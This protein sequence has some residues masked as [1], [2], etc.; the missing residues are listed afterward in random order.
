MN[1]L[2]IQKNRN[3]FVLAIVSAMM[4]VLFSFMGAPFLRALFI[5]TK[6]RVFW[7][8]A[9][10]LVG[11]LLVAGATNY[12]IAE[13]AVYAGA[14]W[15]TLGAYS[16]LEKRGIS[17][18]KSGLISL[19][20]GLLLASAGYFFILKNLTTTDLLGEMVEPLRAAINKVTSEPKERNFYVRVLPGIFV[21]G[22]I[23]SLA[24]SFAFEAKVA[25]M[26]KIQHE[27]VVSGLRWLEFSLPGPAIWTALFALL[28]CEFDTK[29]SLLFS[30]SLNIL[31]ALTVAFFFQGVV[32]V[33]SM[34]RGYRFGM[35]GRIVTYVL[36]ILQ[37]A[38]FV[39]FVG[40][41]DYWANFRRLV[42]KNKNYI[43]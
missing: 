10:L 12:K 5:S 40:F 15:M 38:P 22:L 35:F 41:V 9:I 17:W 1:L 33:E 42:R 8:T 30:I 31:I 39:V 4:S 29:E 14:T 2:K 24:F 20:A 16:E 6:S 34:L 7:I 26:F 43:N 25:K 32:V 19:S 28:I 18:A 36:I 27:R 13:A 23:A 21:S 37:L 11:T 3:V